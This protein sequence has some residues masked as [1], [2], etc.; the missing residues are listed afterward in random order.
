MPDAVDPNVVVRVILHVLRFVSDSRNATPSNNKLKNR[1]VTLLIGKK[2]MLEGLIQNADL[3][4]RELGTPHW[5]A[6]HRG[7]PGQGPRNRRACRAGSFPPALRDS[8]AQVLGGSNVIFTS[9]EGL[10]AFRAEFIELRDVKIPANSEAIGAAASQGDLSENAE[11][12][13]ALEDQRNLTNQAGEMEARLKKAKDLREVEIPDDVVAPGVRVSVQDLD[14]NSE[15]QYRILGPWDG[16]FGDDII[17]YL[18]PLAGGL[19]GLE[20]GEEAT[21]DLPT[22]PRRLKVQSIEKL[23]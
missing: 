14:K 21:I 6:C 20:V 7:L 5:P 22:G 2:G 12:D 17:S 4:N 11:Y 3:K 8:G 19:L 18:A 13:A 1:I 9:S 15:E 10:E 16:R 23:F